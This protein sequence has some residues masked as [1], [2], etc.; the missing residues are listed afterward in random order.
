MSFKYASLIFGS[1]IPKEQRL[2]SL[3]TSLTMGRMQEILRTSTASRASPSAGTA[4]WREPPSPTFWSA[5]TPPTAPLPLYLF[6]CCRGRQEL[7]IILFLSS[8]TQEDKAEPV[9][10]SG[11][12]G[13]RSGG[14][15]D[16]HQWTQSPILPQ[17]QLP[18]AEAPGDGSG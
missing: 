15:E 4:P 7:L 8:Q 3:S 18:A 14:A 1:H 13:W 11:V 16:V 10:V 12:W 5:G 17:R 6:T 2:R 9:G